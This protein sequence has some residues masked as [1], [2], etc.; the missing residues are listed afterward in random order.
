MLPPV[1]GNDQAKLKEAK[2]VLKLREGTEAIGNDCFR[3]AR[4]CLY[5]L[6]HFFSAS[7]RVVRRQVD[8]P[9]PNSS[10]ISQMGLEFIIRSFVV[11][12]DNF[13]RAARRDRNR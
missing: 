13:E 3:E 10:E 2:E 8:V 5:R 7:S 6:T 4:E 11:S 1:I 12:S 9:S